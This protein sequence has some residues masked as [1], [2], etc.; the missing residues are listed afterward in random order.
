M[1]RRYVFSL[2]G[3]VAFAALL[4]TSTSAMAGCQGYCADRRVDG[5]VYAGCEMIYDEHD[6]L[7]DV[8][9]FYTSSRIVPLEE[10]AY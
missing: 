2:F 10:Y 9:C 8:K 1:L 5:G 4:T 3:G 7:Q 6:T